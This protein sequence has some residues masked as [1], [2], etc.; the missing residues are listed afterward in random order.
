MEKNNISNGVN[1]LEITSRDNEK[2]KFLKKLK[3]SKY[4]D[5][6]GKFFVEN[7][8]IIADAAKSGFVFESLFVTQSFIEKNRKKFDFIL[9]SAGVSEYY[10]IGEKVNESFSDLETAPGIAAIYSKPERK[11]D[12]TIP[13]V[14]LN[15]ISDPGNLGTILRSALAFNL[16]NIV[17]DE[18]SADV[19]NH[20]TIQAARDA[21]FKV[22][23]GFDMKRALLSKIKRAMKVFSTRLEESES[24]GI[25][26]GEKL[27][28]LALGS[29]TR[30]VDKKI[31]AISDRF[32]KIEMG[33]EIES[34]NVASAAAIIFYEI[35][36]TGKS[37]PSFFKHK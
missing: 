34:L 36:K 30:G 15:G 7:A 18:Y 14:Y 37:I 12:F 6:F 8:T 32:I 26:K 33:G 24:I 1:V 3:K 35:Y 9:K 21:I 4:R 20:K 13:V 5:Q 19:F 25:L 23:I 31:L 22:N 29:E 11:I 2:I 27:F 17:V 10:V 16:K 28:C